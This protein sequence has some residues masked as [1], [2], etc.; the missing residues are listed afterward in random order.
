MDNDNFTPDGQDFNAGTGP[1]N[2]LSGFGQDTTNQNFGQTADQGF[3]QSFG[4]TPDQGFGQGFGQTPD[5]GFGQ[6]FG[7]TPDQGFGQSFG[8]TA[9]QGFNQSFGQTADQ[10]FNQ[11]FGQN[12]NQ[13]YNQN[14]GQND[15]GTVY[16]AVPVQNGKGFSIA[17]MVCGICSIVLCW[18][19]GIP[20]LVLGIVAVAL[21]IKSKS[22]NNDVLSGMAKAGLVCGVIGAVL[23]ALYIVL[24]VIGI[25]LGT[26]GSLGNIR[27]YL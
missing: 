23:S 4:Q 2:G 13:G 5:Q 26:V 3:G 1:D 9:D 10:G 15:Y 14:Y 24:A 19:Y 17:S 18:C 21:A 16:N 12:A 25:A 6:G 27:Y 8:Q 11:N 7:Q 22:M 20:G